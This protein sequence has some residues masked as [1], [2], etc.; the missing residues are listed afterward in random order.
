MCACVWCCWNGH[1][2]FARGRVRPSCNTV[3][4]GGWLCLLHEAGA[5]ILLLVCTVPLFMCALLGTQESQ[6][7]SLHAAP[8]HRVVNALRGV[9]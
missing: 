1:W 4:L 2:S 6:H 5:R 7:C 9:E 3:L 8:S